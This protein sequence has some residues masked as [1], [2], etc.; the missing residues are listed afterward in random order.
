L[1]YNKFFKKIISLVLNYIRLWDRAAADRAD[2]FVANS[3]IVQKR[4]AKYYK[5]DSRLVYPPVAVEKFHLSDIGLIEKE[6]YFLA[7][8]RLTP[9]K[10]IDIAIQAFR[11]LGG[12]FKL[13]IFGDGIDL[14]RL[15][16][17]AGDSDNIE[18]LGRV[19]DAERAELYSLCKAFINPQEEDFGITAVEAMASGRPV[20]AYDR[21][22]AKETVISGKTG[23][24]INRQCVQAL[25]EAVA[26]FDIKKYDPLFIRENSLKYSTERFKKEMKDLINEEYRKFTD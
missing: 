5:R 10:R 13:K 18:F 12:D 19:N 24:F 22:G 11:E 4:I 7:G 20:I 26:G 14:H 8:C 16:K 6:N 17:I 15:K 2:F 1:K 3:K 9:Y 25:K 21:G 23:E